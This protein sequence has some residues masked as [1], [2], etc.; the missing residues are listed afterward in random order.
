MILCLTI[1]FQHMILTSLQLIVTITDLDASLQK[2]IVRVIA[3]SNQPVVV[4]TWITYLLSRVEFQA[5]SWI[6][7]DS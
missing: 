5:F 1:Y 7:S 4:F 6:G 3:L 2:I